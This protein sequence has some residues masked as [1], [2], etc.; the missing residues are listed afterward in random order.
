MR[1]HDRPLDP[2]AEALE[3]EYDMKVMEQVDRLSQ[4]LFQVVYDIADFAAEERERSGKY[5][6]LV[7]EG[8]SQLEATVETMT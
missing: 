8:A 5:R 2:E 1:E 6:A 3:D 4:R 7:A